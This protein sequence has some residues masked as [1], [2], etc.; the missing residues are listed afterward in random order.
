M[1]SDLILFVAQ[2]ADVNG[3]VDLAG[4]TFHKASKWFTASWTVGDKVYLLAALDEVELRK[5]L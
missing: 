1:K 2:Q 4:T 5:R 3:S